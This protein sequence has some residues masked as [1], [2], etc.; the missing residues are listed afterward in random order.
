LVGYTDLSVEELT[1]ILSAVWQAN[2]R[3]VAGI[4]FLDAEGNNVTISSVVVNHDAE[5]IHVSVLPVRESYDDRV[6]RL[7]NLLSPDLP[8]STKTLKRNGSG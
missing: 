2:G 4:Q 7:R 5:A 3:Q 1:E 8:D 6:H